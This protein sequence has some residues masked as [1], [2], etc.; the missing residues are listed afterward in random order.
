[1]LLVRRLLGIKTYVPCSLAMWSERLSNLDALRR[2]AALTPQEN[3]TAE[4]EVTHAD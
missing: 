2:V 4:T 3:S 1:M